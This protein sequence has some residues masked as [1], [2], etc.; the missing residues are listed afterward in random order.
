M[1]ELLYKTGDYLLANSIKRAL[2]GAGLA[3]VTYQGLDIVLDTLLNNAVSNIQSASTVAL[4]FMSLSGIDT[5]LSIVASAMIARISITQAHL[6][7]T[8]A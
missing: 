5:S 3:V 4:S 2:S 8:K 1:G 6:F 7:L